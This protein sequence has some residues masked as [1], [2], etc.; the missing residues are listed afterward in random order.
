MAPVKV[1]LGEQTIVVPLNGTTTVAELQALALGRLGATESDDDK[2]VMVLTMDP[3]AELYQDDPASDVLTEDAAVTIIHASQINKR[4]RTADQPSPMED[5]DGALKVIW[6]TVTGASGSLHVDAAQSSISVIASYIESQ[7]EKAEPGGGGTSVELYADRGHPL[8]SSAAMKEK[9]LTELG[10]PAD[11]E[12]RIYA[13][14]HAAF[15]S[16]LDA[17]PLGTADP[18]KGLWQLFVKDE[19]SFVVRADP[20]DT[21]AT[22]KLKI[23]AKKGIEVRRQRLV[24]CSTQ[25]NEESRTLQEIGLKNESTLFLVCRPRPKSK[26]GRLDRWGSDEQDAFAAELFEP[27]TPQSPDGLA[28][29]CSVLRVLSRRLEPEVRDKLLGA[30][31]RLTAFP[32]LIATMSHVLDMQAASIDFP[33]R[34]ALVEGSF[35]LFRRIAPSQLAAGGFSDHAVF[36]ASVRCWAFVLGNLQAD[37]AATDKPEQWKTVNLECAISW[38][39][40][41]DEAVVPPDWWCEAMNLELRGRV[42]SLQHLLK[43]NR[44]EPGERPLRQDELLPAAPEVNGLLAGHPNMT[45]AVIWQPP[46]GHATPFPVGPPLLLAPTGGAWGA[47]LDKIIKE[48]GDGVLKVKSAVELK[49]RGRLPALTHDPRAPP[50]LCVAVDKPKS[51]GGVKLTLFHPLEADES[52]HGADD[53]V[54]QLC[55][56]SAADDTSAVPVVSRPPLEAIV[57]LLDKSASMSRDG[58]V[59]PNL[60][61]DPVRTQAAFRP[62][63]AVRFR[64]G[65]P[66]ENSDGDKLQLAGTPGVVQQAADGMCERDEVLVR[67][68]T[69]RLGNVKVRKA[70]LEALTPRGI[71]A[72]TPLS[73]M[74]AVKQLFSGFAN[75]SM[76]YD[77]PHTIG[78]TTFSDVA[79][80][81]RPLTEAFESFKTAVAGVA[82]LGQ[83]ALYDGLEMAR[84]ELAAFVAGLDPALVPSEGVRRR[85]LVLT[86][87]DDT[88]SKAEAHGVCAALQKDGVTVDA[89]VI[90][91]EVKRPGELR[92][93]CVATGGCA[94]HP[95]DAHAALRLFE[96]ETVLALRRRALSDATRPKERVASAD[97]LRAHA[98]G[99]GDAGG[100]DQPPAARVPDGLQ[101]GAK[102]PSFTLNTARNDLRG[103]DLATG[104]HK[105][106]LRELAKYVKD[107]HP[108][109]EVFP[110]ERQLDLWQLLLKGPD[111]TPY[112][113]GTFELWMRFGDEYPLE[114]P[115]VRFSTPIHHCNINSHGRVCHSVFDRNWSADTSVRRVLDCLYGLLLAPEPEDPLDSVLALQYLSSRAQY[116]SAATELTRKSA[117]G[118]Y[119]AARKKLL[120]DKDDDA[121][122]GYP[123]NLVCKITHKLFEDPVTT[124]YGHTISRGALLEMLRRKEQCPITGNPLTYAEAEQLPITLSVRESVDAYKRTQP[125]W[126]ADEV[127]E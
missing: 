126:D 93:I 35:A 27:M 7:L 19:R 20:S 48:F 61:F 95:A 76:A 38:E 34:I 41:N 92:S 28:T 91:D 22:L 98:A 82:P 108:H 37:D 15:G 125:W 12:I 17:E 122:D 49:G 50:R 99:R 66:V 78:L 64:A 74:E 32:P 83:T 107:P 13:V 69:R 18:T 94:F 112:A 31:R 97:E 23:K 4:P 44:D 84:L 67:F 68:R 110:L 102:L 55:A 25:L 81:V 115:E 51:A 101:E 85:I 26:G 21:V 43:K 14:R 114:A 100:W 109:I 103:R 45:E 104:R 24:R 124:K 58:F 71:T 72:L 79:Q 88:S 52:T 80:R 62:G 106:I 16:A 6:S 56:D 59:V 113:G 127:I 10:W 9:P 119:A 54:A 118:S 40:I 2:F 1:T 70:S 36:E 96:C 60:D 120:G 77:L 111:Q 5:P 73:R 65:A 63:E 8:G 121:N 87:G 33:Q 53:L 3:R 105:R 39:P 116:N 30:L 47:E 42:C 89:V 117:L 86:D 75:R 90:G 57:V 11:G 29:F 46:A 123:P